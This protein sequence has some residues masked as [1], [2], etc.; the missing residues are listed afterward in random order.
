MILDVGASLVDA[1]VRD[2]WDDR[3][4]PGN[5]KGCPCVCMRLGVSIPDREKLRRGGLVHI[6]FPWLVGLR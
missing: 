3:E 2:G 6:F 1:Q 5:H 4:R